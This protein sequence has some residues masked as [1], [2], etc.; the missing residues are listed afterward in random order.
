[1]LFNLQFPSNDETC[2]YFT[3]EQA[4]LQ[5]L[6]FDRQPYCQWTSSSNDVS[7]ISITDDVSTN[8][9]TSNTAG[10]SSSGSC[11][12][13]ESEFSMQTI[14]L[15]SWL[16]LVLAGPVDCFIDFIFDT[17]ILAPSYLAIEDQQKLLEE[18]AM[19]YGTSS[20]IVASTSSTDI[21][22]ISSTK[23]LRRNKSSKI[24][25]ATTT[26]AT[27]SKIKS[28]ILVTKEFVNCRYKMIV[29]LLNHHH[30]HHHHHH[31]QPSSITSDDESIYRLYQSF[32]TSF[33]TYRQSLPFNKRV[34]LDEA[35]EPFF[36][37]QY[38]DTTAITVTATDSSRTSA[39]V[40]KYSRTSSV[41]LNE[42]ATVNLLVK[43][44]CKELEAMPTQVTLI[45][46]HYY[47]YYYYYYYHRL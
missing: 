10:V 15:I 29:D 14:L 30:H 44:C 8:T 4:C 24:S 18:E 25:P 41:I 23:K 33:L 20:N 34:T 47:Y 42:M 12:F 31:H 17:F 35:W 45:I 2:Q 9:A 37:E 3:N 26:S 21:S 13:N 32:K 36:E 19:N 1:M 40:K 38:I 28:T 22:T 11:E 5:R 43:D 16:Q 39:I 27:T 6:N 46:N 7:S